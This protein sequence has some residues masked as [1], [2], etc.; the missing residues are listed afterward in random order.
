M[1]NKLI[2]LI[3]QIFCFI[4]FIIG[5]ASVYAAS[6]DDGLTDPLLVTTSD[7]KKVVSDAAGN[8]DLID[9]NMQDAVDDLAGTC[10]KGFHCC[11]SGCSLYSDHDKDNVC[12]RGEELEE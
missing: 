9:E 11:C 10:P 5:N 6:T 7:E 1:K 4:S 3:I 12:D 8:A 2:L